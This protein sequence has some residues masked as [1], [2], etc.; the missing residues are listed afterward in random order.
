MPT[1]ITNDVLFCEMKEV[2]AQL[3]QHNND[4]W[5]H[6]ASVSDTKLAVSLY[7]HPQHPRKIQFHAF[8]CG[9]KKVG[10]WELTGPPTMEDFQ[11]IHKGVQ[12]LLAEF[13]VEALGELKY[14]RDRAK[15]AKWKDYDLN[16]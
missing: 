9:V 7:Y 3:D 5:S 16:Q 15:Q 13:Q 10:I 2:L 14:H 12:E 6:T 1:V 11:F 8:S 4:G